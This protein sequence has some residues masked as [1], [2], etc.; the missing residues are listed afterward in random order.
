M[1]RLDALAKRASEGRMDLLGRLYNDYLMPGRWTHY[2]AMLSAAKA[3]GYRFV[4][5][6][7]AEA[8][9]TEGQPRLFFLRHDIDT[10][11]P[12]TRTMFAIEQEL[13]ITSTY[14]FRRCTA[15]PDLMHAIHA[16]GSEVGYHYEEI[17]DHV[18][19]RGLRRAEEVLPAMESLRRQFLQNLEAFENRLGAKVH[20]VAAHGDF[21]NRRLGLANTTL[22]SPQLRQAAGIRLEAYDGLLTGQVSFRAT[23]AMYPGLW[24]PSSPIEAVATQSPVI[25]FLAHPRHWQRAPLHRFHI[26]AQRLFDELRYRLR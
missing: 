2:R 19:A 6:Q 13:G 26:D 11:V 14:Y 9:L 3:N 15:D 23:D 8:A 24:K 4:R 18:K 25:L 12:L 21:A 16:S 17:S 20:T 1:N 10:D 5:H 22:M 7:D